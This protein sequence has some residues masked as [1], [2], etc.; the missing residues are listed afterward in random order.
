MSNT[1]LH[2][3]NCESTAI[4]CSVPRRRKCSVN[5]HFGI[6]H[7]D[8]RRHINKGLKVRC[9]NTV[10]MSHQQVT[11]A[12]AMIEPIAELVG[13]LGPLDTVHVCQ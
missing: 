10:N 3:S 5:L 8:S 7:L 2:S 6:I 9:W 11:T 4:R 1:M 13:K 12:A